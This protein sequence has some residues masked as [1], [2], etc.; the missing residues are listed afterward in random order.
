MA[1][2][3]WINFNNGDQNLEVRN[4]INAFNTDVNSTVDQNTLD[5]ASNTAGINTQSGRITNIVDGVTPI[6]K[7][8]YNPQMTLATH[9]EGTTYYD[10]ATGSLKVQGPI[11]DIEVSVGHDM[12]IH[13]I[14]NT[15]AIIEKGMACRHNGVAGGIVQ[16]AKAIADTF[17]NARVFGVAQQDIPN[18]AEGALITFGQIHSLD[19]SGYPTG[20]PLYLSDTVAGTYTEVQPTI[21]SRVGGSLVQDALTGELFV[22]IINNSN[23]PT[24]LGGVQGQ[25][26]G[27]ETYTVTA[28]SQDITNYA[29]TEEAVMG[30]DP[31]LGT[32]TLSNDG[33]YRVS[34]GCSLTFT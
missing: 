23:L 12:H 11:S 14:N 6:E 5:I 13:V 10:S 30:A 15:G 8:L 16:V 34:Y 21:I 7:T 24:V 1:L 2:T 27:N 25:T 4:K 32:V 18:G 31:L 28:L 33:K 17:D 26:S 29:L 9:V 22:S 19:T 20:V 3:P